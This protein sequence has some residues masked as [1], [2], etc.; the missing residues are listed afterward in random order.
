MIDDSIGRHK[1]SLSPSLPLCLSFPI[2]VFV[3]HSPSLSLRP[4]V[5]FVYGYVIACVIVCVCVWV[6]VC[7][8][9]CVR[10]C[11]CVCVCAVSYTHLT[12]PTRRTV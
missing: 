7:V 10:V 3:S 9:V 2:S 6:C 4:D 1:R 5:L 12:L 8:C 11:V